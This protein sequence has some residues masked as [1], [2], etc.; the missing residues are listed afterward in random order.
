M[1]LLYKGVEVAKGGFTPYLHRGRRYTLQ[2]PENWCSDFGFSMCIVLPYDPTEYFIR[3]ASLSISINDQV[4]S[5]IDSQNDLI[6]EEDCKREE[7]T[8]VGYVSFG[9][10][11]DSA[12]WDQSYKAISFEIEDVDLYCS[13]LAVRLVDKKSSSGLMETSIDSSDYTPNFEI[14]HDTPSSLAIS[15]KGFSFNHLRKFSW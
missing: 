15:N 9:L 2:L 7:F 10:L 6:W 12:W 8:C 14:K 3:M 1:F 11:R 4:T 13:G 5:G